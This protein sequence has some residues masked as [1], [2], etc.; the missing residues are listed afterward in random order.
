MLLILKNYNF[1]SLF[2]SSS[3]LTL[4]YILEVNLDTICLNLTFKKY[5]RKWLKNHKK[6]RFYKNLKNLRNREIGIKPL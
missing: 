3:K 4:K 6:I 2:F 1:G 5:L